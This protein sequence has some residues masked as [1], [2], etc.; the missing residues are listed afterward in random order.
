[1][2]LAESEPF[3]R[4]LNVAVPVNSPLISAGLSLRR[5]RVRRHGRDGREREVNSA[6]RSCG[7]GADAGVLEDSIM[8]GWI[9][10]SG[11]CCEWSGGVILVFGVESCGMSIQ[12]G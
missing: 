10:E 3:L 4:K 8:L 5:V 11:C 9:L 7:E 12:Q 1:M 6:E 2:S